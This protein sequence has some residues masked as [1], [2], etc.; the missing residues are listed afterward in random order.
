MVLLKFEC[1][2]FVE[3]SKFHM[4]IR[5]KRGKPPTLVLQLLRNEEGATAT[6]G[7]LIIREREGLPVPIPQPFNTIEK[8]WLGN[9]ANVSRIPPKTFYRLFKKRIDHF[10]EEVIGI[11]SSIA[12]SKMVEGVVGR[13]G[14]EI[15]ILPARNIQLISNGSIGI[16]EQFTGMGTGFAPNKPFETLRDYVFNAIDRGEHVLLEIRS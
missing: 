5:S 2:L 3:S 1:D 9:E 15:A 11:G 13:P 6:N 16:V 12:T 10:D 8:P 4:P 14:E 7:K